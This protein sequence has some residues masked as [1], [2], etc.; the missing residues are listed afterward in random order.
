MRQ[1][2]EVGDHTLFLGEVV[3]A[4]FL[5]DEETDGPPHG[6]HPHELR[7]LTADAEISRRAAGAPGGAARA[8]A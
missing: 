7:R 3:N 5:K 6:G 4:A 2:V 1:P 8:A